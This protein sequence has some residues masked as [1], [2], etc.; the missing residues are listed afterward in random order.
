MTPEN[1][2]GIKGPSNL[3]FFAGVDTGLLLFSEAFK[4][5]GIF[6][7][8]RLFESWDKLGEPERDVLPLKM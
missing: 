1:V 8:F 5:D 2:G 6:A 4:S 7:P 3:I